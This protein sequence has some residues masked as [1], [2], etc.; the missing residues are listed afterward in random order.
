M[1]GRDL[2]NSGIGKTTITKAIYNLIASKFESTC[3]LENI[4]NNS[5]Q[6]GLVHLQN[7]LLSK[8]L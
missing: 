4:G 6:K 8:I 2:R 7:K 3:F 5:C 1:H